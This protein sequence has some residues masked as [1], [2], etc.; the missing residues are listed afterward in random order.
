MMH[1]FVYL[2]TAVSLVLVFIG[3][4]VIGAELLGIEK[5]PAVISLGVTATLLIGGIAL[6]LWQTRKV[7][8]VPANPVHPE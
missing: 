1:R 3:A 2:K 8:P 4:K 7:E 6:S 5:V